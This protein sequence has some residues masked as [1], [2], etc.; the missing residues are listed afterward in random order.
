M[1]REKIIKEIGVSTQ[2]D[3]ATELPRFPMT[4]QSQLLRRPGLY[5][6]CPDCRDVTMINLSFLFYF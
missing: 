2:K 1:Q 5:N 6:S 3:T 4:F